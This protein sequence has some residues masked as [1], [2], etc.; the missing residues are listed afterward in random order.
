MERRRIV[1]EYLIVIW[2]TG[3][4][5]PEY[6]SIQS[7]SPPNALLRTLYDISL[8]VNEKEIR[9]IEIFTKGGGK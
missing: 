3:R 1:K 7:D 5:W 9:K 6:R 8:Y 4:S 2:V